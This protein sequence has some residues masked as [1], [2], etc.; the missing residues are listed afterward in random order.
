MTPVSLRTIEPVKN[1]GKTISSQ[2][3]IVYVK[4]GYID[5]LK[6][7]PGQIVFPCSQPDINT[8]RPYSG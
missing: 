2:S 8:C 6:M 5:W 3:P 4:M 7:N 1:Q